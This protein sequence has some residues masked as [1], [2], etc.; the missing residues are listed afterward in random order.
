VLKTSITEL[1]CWRWAGH[2]HAGDG[3]QPRRRQARSSLCSAGAAGVRWQHR[4]RSAGLPRCAAG[5]C[6]AA[7]IARSIS[8]G[9]HFLH[10]FS[11]HVMS[12]PICAEKANME[13]A[14]KRGVSTQITDTVSEPHAAGPQAAVG[15]GDGGAGLGSV[16]TQGGLAA[17]ARQEA[18]GGALLVA[19]LLRCMRPAGGGGGGG[20]DDADADPQLQSRCRHTRVARSHDCGSCAMSAASVGA[21]ASGQITRQRRMTRMTNCQCRVQSS[22]SQ[23]IIICCI[24]LD[25]RVCTNPG[26]RFWSCILLS[27]GWQLRRSSSCWRYAARSWCR[28]QQMRGRRMKRRQQ[29]L[30]P[31]PL[32]LPAPQPA[33]LHRCAS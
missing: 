14:A 4:R 24:M 12:I 20:G 25:S 19:A 1:V 10:T 13:T 9:P 21:V 28:Q 8:E 15:P 26:Y 18:E 11:K 3:V 22:D 27:P 23:Q 29:Q 30:Q 6:A 31:A 32:Q 2:C 5:D 17:A 7:A 33:A 16:A